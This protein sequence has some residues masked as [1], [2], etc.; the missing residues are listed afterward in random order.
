MCEPASLGLASLAVG[1][2]STGYNFYAREREARAASQNA[3]AQAEYQAQLAANEAASQIQLA[4]NEISKG[5]AEREE[6]QREAAQSLGGMRAGIGASGFE[7]DSGA[8]LSLLMDSAREGQYAA[9]K[10]QAS[11]NDA[12]WAQLNSATL[13]NNRKSFAQWPRASL[14]SGNGASLLGSIGRGI[15]QLGAY[16]AKI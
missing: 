2:L 9:N 12:A 13:A 10:S 1:A 15:G 3:K 4:Q 11:F 8:K 7:M 14:G 6:K 5:I 16:L